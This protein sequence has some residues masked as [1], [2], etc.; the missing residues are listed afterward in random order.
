MESKNKSWINTLIIGL[1]VIISCIAIAF[2]FYHFKSDSNQHITAT[3]SASV[4]FEADTVIWRGCFSQSAYTPQEAYNKI[5]E[6]SSRVKAYLTDNGIKKDEIVFNSVD[7]SRTYT[8]QYNDEG[9][10]VG[11]VADGYELRQEFEVSSKDIDNIEKVSREISSLLDD[12]VELES[13]SPEYYYSKL[14]EL[15][16]NLIDKAS[17]NAKERIDIIA[18]NSGAKI[19]KLKNS[20]LGVFQITAQNS[21]TS[22]Y[23]YDGAFDTHSRNKTA[24]IT[25]HLEYGIK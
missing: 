19:G 14:D 15:K 25:V 11:S 17:K 4:D 2:G 8:E 18:K 5:K 3:G 7:I 1:C 9:D 23:S 6:D 20:N 13:Y 16:L 21:G 22:D 24:S 10:Y 12:G